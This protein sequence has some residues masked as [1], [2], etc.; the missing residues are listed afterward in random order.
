VE[1]TAKDLNDLSLRLTET[2]E[3]YQK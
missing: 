2:V 1:K 3:Q